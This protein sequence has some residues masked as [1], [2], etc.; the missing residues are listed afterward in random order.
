MADLNIDK[1]TRFEALD[2]LLNALPDLPADA[3]ILDV[4]GYPGDFADFCGSRR[5]IVTADM[6]PCD[7]PEYVQASGTDLPFADGEFEAVVSSD[8]FEH[9]PRDQRDKFISEALRC[10][11]HYV[12]IGCPWGHP[13]VTYCEDALRGLH[14]LLYPTPHPWLD[15]HGRFGLPEMDDT[16]AAI[17]NAGAADMA[18]IPSM[19]LR[20]W[21]YHHAL[22]IL[23]EAFSPLAAM[24]QA[25]DE[26]LKAIPGNGDELFQ[27][28]YRV[29][30]LASKTGL[31]PAALHKKSRLVKQANGD[32]FE[33]DM[34]ALRSMAQAFRS[35]A[36]GLKEMLG[37]EGKSPAGAGVDEAYVRR[38]EDLINKTQQETSRLRRLLAKA[39][40]RQSRLERQPIIRWLRRLGLIPRD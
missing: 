37:A 8:T 30:Y 7:R 33:R 6:P 15:E 14:Q 18:V 27:P 13:A 26:L 10:S 9:I 22:S 28:C 38:L 39:E 36:G 34:E 12:I 25:A 17:R 21:F 23:G 19:P 35:C 2:A 11:S 4:G 16:L 29:F 5:R 1:M 20:P 32:L 40:K 31:L 3:P 24:P